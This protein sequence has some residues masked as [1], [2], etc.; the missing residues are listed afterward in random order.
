MKTFTVAVRTEQEVEYSIEASN[1]E[2]A[3]DE[4]EALASMGVWHGGGE[5]VWSDVYVVD[6]EEVE[7]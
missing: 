2:T 6:A 5:L 4:A 7:G 1:E 3:K